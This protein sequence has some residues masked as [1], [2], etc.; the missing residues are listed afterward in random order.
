MENY[1]LDGRCTLSNNAT[2]NA[3]RPFTVG[4]K[5]WLFADSPKGADASAAVY[6]II[7]TAKANDLNVYTYLEYL[8]LCMPDT[9]W[10]NHPEELDN[11]MPWSETVKTEC[12]N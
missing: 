9:D 3:I 2:E 5:N 12:G 1:L 4:Q 7:K 8:L 10:C 11:L 6:S